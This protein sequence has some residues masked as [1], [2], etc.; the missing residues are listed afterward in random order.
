MSQ[1]HRRSSRTDPR[2][3]AL[4]VLFAGYGGVLLT[5]GVG[6]LVRPQSTGSEAV[7]AVGSI[8]AG[9]IFVAACRALWEPRRWSYPLAVIASTLFV[10]VSGTF[11]IGTIGDGPGG[12]AFGSLIIALAFLAVLL[13]LSIRSAVGPA[14]MTSGLGRTD[15][16]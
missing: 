11:A 9:L 13:T 12:L 4:G 15:H 5:S 6:V 14:S 8:F 16:H 1:P 2:V 3:A 7:F 10:V